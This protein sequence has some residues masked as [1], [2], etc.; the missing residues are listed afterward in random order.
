LLAQEV[1][2]EYGAR[3]RFVVEDFGASALADRFGIDKY[4]AIII[5]D[6]L[7]SAPEDFYAWGSAGKGKYLPWTELA[8]RKKFQADLRRMIDIRLAGL[9]LTSA[10]R[11]KAAVAIPTL[12]LHEPIT[13]LSGQ[14]FK[15]A[16]LSG[17]PLIVE[18]WAP[19][20]PPCLDTMRWL[21]KLDPKS[22]NVV[23][24]AVESE[25]PAVER[26]V[27]QMKPAGRIAMAS[28]ELARA[29]G[30]IP[31]VP[32]LFLADSKGKVVRV[33]YGAPPDL[34]E[35]IEKALGSVK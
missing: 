13:D 27:D 34:H 28:P 29:M 20:C 11:P 6:A 1:V 3:V 9:P 2:R 32:L 4:P 23:A 12:P 17:K 14:T 21:K 30:G 22:A 10:S 31:A 24:L 18:F 7:V 33:F 35:Q 26:L 16:D 15:L 8:N 25:R 5:D 19:W